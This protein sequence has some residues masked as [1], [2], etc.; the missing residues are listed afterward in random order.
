MNIKRLLFIAIILT[1]FTSASNAVNSEP[2]EAGGIISDLKLHKNEIFIDG[3][4]YRIYPSVKV[5]LLEENKV[6][7]IYELKNN[8]GIEFKYKESTDGT[9]IILEIGTVPLP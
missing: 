5:N 7:N 6:A 4:M 1:T 2:Y 3:H 9:K 8:M